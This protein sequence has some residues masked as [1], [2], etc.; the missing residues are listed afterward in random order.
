MNRA[1][2]IVYVANQ[3]SSSV[4]V[5]DE[6]KIGTAN[7]V[8]ATIGVGGTPSAVAVNSLTNRVYVAN[9]ND[10]TVSVIDGSCECVAATVPT[11]FCCVDAVAVNEA[12]NRFYAASGDFVG[13][14][15][16]FDGTSNGT[17]CSNNLSG[18][19]GLAVNTTGSRIF[20]ASEVAGGG[21]YTILDG[22]TCGIL[23]PT[24]SA[25]GQHQ[26]LV[27]NAAD[28]SVY[29]T[30][31]NAARLCGYNMTSGSRTVD[32]PLPVSDG[33]GFGTALDP[34]NQ[35]LFAIAGQSTVT[36]FQV[37]VASRSITAS[38]AL[39]RI[40]RSTTRTTLIRKLGSCSPGCTTSIRFLLSQTD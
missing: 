26:Q 27:Y 30:V 17:L 2:H 22:N 35:Q 10:N 16:I 20:A 18:V 28:D 8:I 38:V 13:T 24:Q 37:D 3:A 36:M 19:R 21:T 34:V 40:R 15:K 31:F 5:I 1:T 25:C 9:S 11:G 4:S 6:S 23:I 12:T 7:A 14:V 29:S 32:M 39:T 33:S